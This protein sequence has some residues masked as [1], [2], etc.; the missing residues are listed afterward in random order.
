MKSASGVVPFPVIKA[1]A[2]GKDEIAFLPAALEI[3]EAPPNPVGRAV[4]AVIVAAFSVA[5]VWACL[6]TVD[7]VAV[8]PG[9]VIPSGRTKVIQPFET[10]VVRA[11]KVVDGQT[12]RA[13]DVLVDL[14]STMN[15]AELG[16]LR[17]DLAG[18]QLEA[19]RLR[20]ALS[21]AGDPVANFQ[22]PENAPADLVRV[23][24]RLLS[25]QTVEQN[26]KLASIEHQVAQKE[27]ERA[28][29]T[30]S[31][32]K[33]EATIPLLQ[34]RVDMRKLLFDKELGSK[35]FYLQELQDLVGQ[36]QEL[37]V[38]KSRYKEADAALAALVETS[39]KT[40]AEYQR[41]LSDDLAKA[42]QRAA[43]LMQDVVK[44]EQRKS[45][46]RLTAPVDGVIQQL[47]IHTV[48]GVVTPAQ[49]LMVIV[50]LESRL[51]IEAMVSNR[52]IGF[53]EVGQDVAL[54]IDTFNFTRY[55]L[56]D[57]KVSSVSHDAITRD[58]PLDKSG[59][60]S[61]GT[62]QDSSE[63]KGQ[64]LVYSARISP[65]RDRM[66]IEDKYVSLSPGMAVSVEIKTGTRTIISYL[67]SPLAR[68]RHESMRER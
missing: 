7:I 6:G 2:R 65:S 25:S 21:D 26:A 22:P 37:L 60:K 23:Q 57:G 13:G 14:D 18:A 11:I 52:D 19:A 12:V 15:E 10:S 8:A 41:S 31:I 3:V 64:E 68:Y 51:E 27:A 30:A 50:P 32:G 55:G 17:S 29:I 28:T 4:G 47:A 56:L 49:A 1:P 34:Q 38:Q 62:E 36:Q 58:K 43:G 20:A 9:K 39:T 35:L 42:E 40:T 53:I 44:A 33:L 46:Q 59:E 54:K 5:I 24:R 48:G 66:L 63:P 61:A 16:H 67:L 45:F